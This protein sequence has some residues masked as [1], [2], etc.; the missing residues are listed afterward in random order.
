MLEDALDAGI[1]SGAQE[2]F[3]YWAGLP[4]DPGDDDVPVRVMV[5]KQ[6]GG[7][8][9]QRLARIFEELLVGGDDRVVAIGADCPDLGPGV[10]DQAFEAL[11]RCDLVLGPA[12]DGGYVLVGLR[13][14]APVLFERVA[15]GT[16]RVLAQTLERAREARLEMVLLDERTDLDRPEDLV[17]F[18][19]RRAFEE[20]THGRRTEAA[21]RR[22]GLLPAPP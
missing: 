4:P 10:I 14:L 16:D 21:L 13:R 22:M 3:L 1:G 9:G 11:E 6:V 2:C 7:D 12:A 17:R 19:I 15:W 5:R 8:L 18:V 20:A